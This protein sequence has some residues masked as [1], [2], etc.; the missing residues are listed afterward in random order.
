MSEKEIKESAATGSS[1]SHLERDSDEE[2][3]FDTCSSGDDKH[4]ETDTEMTSKVTVVGGN[5]T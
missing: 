5:I 2:N 1:G 4:I 3:N